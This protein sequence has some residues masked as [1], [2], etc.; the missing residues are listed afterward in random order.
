MAHAVEAKMTLLDSSSS[1][2]TKI[3]A[4][5]EL[6]TAPAA[7]TSVPASDHNRPGLLEY[8]GDKRKKP[9]TKPV[10]AADTDSD[11]CHL[12]GCLMVYTT[13]KVVYTTLGIYHGIYQRGR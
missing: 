3:R 9:G 4:S 7:V 13:P 2:T 5:D 8:R 12:E 6:G 11:H 1:D 10:P